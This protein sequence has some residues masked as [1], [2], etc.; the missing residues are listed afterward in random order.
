MSR[1]SE[2]LR[3]AF[4]GCGP[5]AGEHA[6]AYS[7]VTRGRVVA[8][9]AR[10]RVHAERFCRAFGIERSYDDPASMLEAERPDLLHI[11]TDP[12]QR[13]A[14]MSLAAEHRVPVVI[15]EKPIAIEG[16]DRARIADL[17]DRTATRFVVNTQL[18]FH[19]RLLAL[20]DDVAEGRVGEI[21]FIDTSAASTILDQGVHLLDLAHWFADH[22]LP[23]QVIAQ[24]SGVSAL[25]SDQPC[26]DITSL[27]IR[28]EGDVRTLLVSGDIASLIEPKEP[29]YMQ[30]RIAVYGSTG[31]VHWTMFGWERVTRL[32]GYATGRH[33]YAE[34]DTR[35]QAALTDAAF[36]LL[37]GGDQVHPT[38]L[39][40][41][42]KQF[43]VV[44]AG[45][46]SALEHRPIDLPFQAP[47]HLLDALRSGLHRAEPSS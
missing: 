38:N 26:P 16:E 4:I 35:A 2:R 5:R 1:A 18:R 27:L 30:K 6:A 22:A 28:F 11:I 34:E 36:A 24:V 41:S 21:R 17:A 40:R 8:A 23:R 44:L 47:D 45:Y 31:Y 29:F 33:V 19:P 9:C 39:T 20:R 15:V 14:L 12:G 43:D 37:E 10:T 42:L 3:S 7:G 13:I 32:G 25:D 46:V